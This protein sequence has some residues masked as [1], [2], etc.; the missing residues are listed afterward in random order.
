M[1][2]AIRNM[3]SFAPMF[4]MIGT[5]MGVTQVLKNV[6]DI[7]N[8]VQG[9]SLA[10]LTTLYGTVFSAVVFM[11]VA[12]KLK[13]LNAQEMLAKEIIVEGIA[14]VMQKEIPLKVEKFLA[15]YLDSKQQK[16]GKKK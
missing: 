5:I 4:G 13:A 16:L 6:T 9:M 10:L 7:G 8:I 11:P 14:M 2:Q 3:G 15:S 12:N 1:S